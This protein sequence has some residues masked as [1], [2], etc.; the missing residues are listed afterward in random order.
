MVLFM[1][2]RAFFQNI[3]SKWGEVGDVL[4]SDDMFESYA[5]KYPERHLI[6]D[7]YPYVVKDM[8]KYYHN[9]FFYRKY[10]DREI[11]KREY[12]IEELKFVNFIKILWLYNTVTFC[13]DLQD[14]SYF[15][16]GLRTKRYF[17]KKISNCK[18][19]S[20]QDFNLL[21]KAL[22]LALRE[23]GFLWIY[24]EEWDILTIINDFSI[25]ILL[26]DEKTKYHI[27]PLL[28]C[29]SLFELKEASNT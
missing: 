27:I 3:L 20:V 4:N 18:Y 14:S 10:K 21:E 22:R 29:C 5:S 12:L 8:D 28:N 6:V 1:E 25:S 15:L 2:N 13:C 17:S 11:K 26:R 16:K 23:A 7:I 19:S 24:F 9:S